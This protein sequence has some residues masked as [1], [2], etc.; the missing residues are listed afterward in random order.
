VE[1]INYG[2]LIWSPL[3]AFFRRL[4]F[5][6]LRVFP[7][8]GF[9]PII[10]FSS[11]LP[12]LENYYFVD[13]DSWKATHTVKKQGRFRQNALL[14]SGVL[15]SLSR[16]FSSFFHRGRSPRTRV[17]WP[18]CG[19]PNPIEEFPPYPK[20]GKVILFS[21][22]DRRLAIMLPPQKALRYCYCCSFGRAAA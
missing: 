22:A 17:E 8:L 18:L 6:F 9:F 11:L 1:P 16:V 7:F 4:V 2:L 12:T 15:R 21:S 5:P 3:D 20:L 13:G 19:Y 10:A 14:L